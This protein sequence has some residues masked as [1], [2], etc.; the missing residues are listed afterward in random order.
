MK[1]IKYKGITIYETDTLME[2]HTPR[3]TRYKN[4]YEIYRP[5]GI[6]ANLCQYRMRATSLRQAREMISDILK[7]EAEK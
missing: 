1:E 4:V 6:P 2:V 5:E 3:G 7:W